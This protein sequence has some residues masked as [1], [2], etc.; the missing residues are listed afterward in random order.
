M[1]HASVERMKIVRY[2]AA[3]GVVVD[4]GKILVLARAVRGEVRLP[5]GHVDEGE[6][7]DQAARRE[8]AEES[9]YHDVDVIADLGMAVVEFDQSDHPDGA[10]H[11]VR[12]ERYYLMSLRSP[13][14]ADGE[15][16][17]EPR[18]VTW[19]DAE[20]VLTF[21]PERQW[22]RRARAHKM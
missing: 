21:E 5:K 2:R 9:G 4:D 22:V 13:A 12:E 17:F 6:S 19:D 7:P 11:V 10:R 8:V 1:R 18:W 20:R 16:Q 14:R 15:A 3:G